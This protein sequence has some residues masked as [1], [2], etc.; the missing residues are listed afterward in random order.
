MEFHRKDFVYTGPEEDGET[1]TCLAASDCVTWRVRAD[2]LDMAFSKKKANQRKEWL[3]SFT[4]GV[5]VDHNLSQVS[6]SDFVNKE[7]IL[8]SMADNARS[9]PSAVDGLKPSQRK[10][11]F[12][13]FKRKLTKEIKVAQL[14]GY[15]SE[16]AAYHHGEDSLHG[17]I[18][19]MAQDYC[20]SNNTNLL[21][22]SGQFGT[23]LLGGKDAASPR[24]IFTRLDPL[25]RL[26]FR[27]SDESLT[28]NLDDDGLSIEP[29]YYVPVI[30]LV[31]VNGS[32]GIGKCAALLVF[33]LVG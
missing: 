31:L 30:P 12:C 15:V 32:D 13:C 33:R 9:I 14:A 6:Y 5:H 27:E 11:L 25:A 23:R 19:N 3:N 29:A 10:V 21:V 17:T 4:D 1:S 28:D 16:H 8:F 7:L 20:G 24:Y 2:M 22:P 26:I 18:I